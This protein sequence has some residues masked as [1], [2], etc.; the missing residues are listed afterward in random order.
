MTIK[1]ALESI[2]NDGIRL[3]A[4]D[5]VE[6][7]ALKVSAKILGRH[8]KGQLVEVVRCKDCKFY[9][10]QTKICDLHSEEPDCYDS[11]H[12]VCF[13]ECDFCSYGTKK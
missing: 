8:I 10:K 5:Y 3:G 6:L 1:E 9:D 2:V 11:G 7:E 12:A 13:A 4:G